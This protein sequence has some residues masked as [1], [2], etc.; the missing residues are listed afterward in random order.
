MPAFNFHKRFAA[1]VESGVKR[2]TIRHTARG[3]KRD[4]R[5]YL[6]TGQRTLSCRKLG[7]GKITDVLPIE[8][9]RTA[10]GE[11]YAAITRGNKQE[12]LAHRDMDNLAKDDG[13]LS[14]E[15]MVAWFEGEYEL[16]FSG[17]LIQWIPIQRKE[18]SA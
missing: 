18:K 1:A 8:I 4:D 11:P 12:H 17:F 16:P 15:E 5:A 7:E 9:G 6:Y 14:G 2:L 3:A 10:C 13:F